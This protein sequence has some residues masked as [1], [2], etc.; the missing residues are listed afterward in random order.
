LRGIKA[1]LL[2]HYGTEDHNTTKTEI[3]MFRDTLDRYGKQYEIHMYKGARH[4][5]LNN[6]QG[7]NEANRHAADESVAKTRKWLRKVLA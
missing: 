7:K 4:A 5:F 1:P 3:H 2:C 6:P